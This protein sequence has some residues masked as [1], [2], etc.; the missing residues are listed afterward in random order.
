MSFAAT[1]LPLWLDPSHLPSP[2][3]LAVAALALV[4][5]Y[6][7]FTLVGFGSAMVASAPLA[8]VMPVPRVIPLLALLDCA[9]AATRGWRQR[10]HID[11]QQL[12][13]L[14][15]TMALGQGLGI[16]LLGRLPTVWL[17]AALGLFILL[18]GAWG[19]VQPAP[20]RLLLRWGWACGVIGGV[21]GGLFGS[22]GF[23]YAAYL[24]R[25]PLERETFRATQA[26]LMA[27]STGL[28]VLLCALTG[29]IDPKLL[30]LALLAV[31]PMLLGTWLGHHLDLHLSKERFLHLL[32]GVLAA[33]GLG[34]LA[35]SLLG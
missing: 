18:Y 16:A 31:P 26:V 7:I 10:R 6:T 11:R 17:G 22:G 25:Q 4:A 24:S 12:L 3:A 35:R 9:G 21:F 5:A 30:G 8:A 15:P 19:L 33:A 2:T 28:R 29:L 32:N 20:P 14:L 27:L 23:L 34:L 1:S 13:R